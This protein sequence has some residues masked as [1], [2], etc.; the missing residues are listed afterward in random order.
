MQ[1]LTD[2][3]SKAG[4]TPRPKS[5][6]EPSPSGTTPHIDDTDATGLAKKAMPS[7]RTPTLA[8]VVATLALA[9]ALALQ[10]LLGAMG[11]AAFAGEIRLANQLGVICTIHGADIPS[12]ETGQPD[13]AKDPTPGRMACLEHCMPAV[14]QAA[15]PP[16]QPLTTRLV[17]ERPKLLAGWR[18]VTHEAAAPYPASGPPPPMRG[19]PL[20]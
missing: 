14:A 17:V 15:A 2:P 3:G 6:W 10:G 18:L 16:S 20:A 11:G 19:P 5:E 12:A 9:Y 1:R 13:R 7:F 8:R 4:M